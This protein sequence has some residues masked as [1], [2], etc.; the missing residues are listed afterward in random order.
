MAI[1]W[2]E[3]LKTGVP[4]IDEQHEEI[5]EVFDK[6]TAAI[7]DGEENKEIGNLLDYL[8]EY[9]TR[10][11]SD[12]ETLMSLYKYAGLEEQRLQHTQFKDNIGKLSEMFSSGVTTKEIAIKVNAT[13]IRYFINHVRKLDREMADIVKPDLKM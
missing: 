5:F 12:E 3:G 8:A 13:L 7:E 1:H 2:E 11:F 10:H 9:A 4:A 6:L